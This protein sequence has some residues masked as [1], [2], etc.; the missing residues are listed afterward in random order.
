MRSLALEYQQGW[1]KWCDLKLWSM[2][3][4]QEGKANL[5]QRNRHLAKNTL[6]GCYDGKPYP[7]GWNTYVSKCFFSESFCWSASFI[8]GQARG[9]PR[10]C[11]MYSNF[12][13]TKGP[14][15]E[16]PS[17]DHAPV[18]GQMVFWGHWNSMKFQVRSKLV[19]LPLSHFRMYKIIPNTNCYWIP[20]IPWN[21]S[22]SEFDYESKA[23]SKWARQHKGFTSISIYTAIR[24][25]H[26]GNHWL[27]DSC[28]VQSCLSPW[29]WSRTLTW[30]G[31]EW[32]WSKGN[33]P[34][35]LFQSAPLFV[36][37][38]FRCPNL[39]NIHL[40]SGQFAGLWMSLEHLLGSWAKGRHREDIGQGNVQSWPHVSSR[41]PELVAPVLSETLECQET[42]ALLAIQTA[43]F[44]NW[45]S[46]RGDLQENFGTG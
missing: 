38:T 6:Y 16:G 5:G 4:E 35:H 17:A 36:S 31:L 29:S 7:F 13:A 28:D 39:T 22:R 12:C 26:F 23:T 24:R 20:G 41:K 8:F 45:R 2:K 40:E 9:P 25:V 1:G 44:V 11:T 14:V 21:L 30:N 18:E 3:W 43:R 34:K 27:S 42:Q 37:W 10:S 32:L 46:C 19:F 15:M 33:R